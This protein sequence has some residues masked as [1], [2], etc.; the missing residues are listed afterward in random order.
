MGAAEEGGE[1]PGLHVWAPGPS[2]GEKS[3]LRGREL[4]LSNVPSHLQ[5]VFFGGEEVG[6]R[7]G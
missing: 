4:C 3:Q 5:R 2:P 7:Y 1:L 6:D